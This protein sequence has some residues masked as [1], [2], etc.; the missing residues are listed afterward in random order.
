MRSRKATTLTELVIA[1][2]MGSLVFLSAIAL[3][4]QALR[5]TS[6][7]QQRA[8]AEAASLRLARQLR[9]DARQAISA[10]L[11]GNQELLLKNSDE[12]NIRYAIDSHILTRTVTSKSMPE[13]DQYELPRDV[14]C[15]FKRNE[16]SPKRLGLIAYRKSPDGATLDVLEM[17]IQ[18]VVAEHSIT[19]TSRVEQPISQFASGGDQ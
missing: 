17:Q 4:H 12:V 11:N 10:N 5:I 8:T 18:F 13:F 1:M 15:R 19:R 6:W 3:V 7:Q 2:W 16:D 14:D 9:E